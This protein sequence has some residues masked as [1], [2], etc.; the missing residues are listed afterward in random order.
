VRT[1]LLDASLGGVRLRQVLIP[2]VAPEIMVNLGGATAADLA[3][4]ER[5]VVDRVKRL[6]GIELE[7]RVRWAGRHRAGST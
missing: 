1:A 2:A 3:L 7:P 5:S 6:Q 4:V